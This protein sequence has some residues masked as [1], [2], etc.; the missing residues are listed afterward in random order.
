[1]N[2]DYNGSCNVMIYKQT[3]FI[4]HG[5]KIPNGDECKPRSPF[6]L[7]SAETRQT[8]PVYYCG[9]TPSSDPVPSISDDAFT[10]ATAF[11]ES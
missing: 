6:S 1:M 9:V 10:L 7:H 4:S 11:D 3:A 2:R 8:F 5:N